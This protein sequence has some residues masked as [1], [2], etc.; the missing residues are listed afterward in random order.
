MIRGKI[1]NSIIDPID[2][3]ENGLV[4]GA[5]EYGIKLKSHVY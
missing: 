4:Q 2:Y 5:V 3:I 1:Y